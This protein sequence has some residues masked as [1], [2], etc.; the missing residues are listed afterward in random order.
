MVTHT[1]RNKKLTVF[2]ELYR[3]VENTGDPWL[4]ATITCPNEKLTTFGFIIRYTVDIVINFSKHSHGLEPLTKWKGESQSHLLSLDLCFKYFPSMVTQSYLS[5]KPKDVITDLIM[6]R[7]SSV[8]H[9]T[10][11]CSKEHET[12][13]RVRLSESF[14][15]VVPQAKRGRITSK[16]DSSTF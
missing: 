1:L 15:S 16:T 13:H 11:T 14:P 9:V 12:T 7:S 8:I 5:I 3:L 10:E 2:L 6:F 4:D